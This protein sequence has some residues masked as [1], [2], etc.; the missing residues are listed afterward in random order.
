MFCAKI[1]LTYHTT[2]RKKLLITLSINTIPVSKKII[3]TNYENQNHF[4]NDLVSFKTVYNQ[5]QI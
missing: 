5:I 1:I 4:L 2:N 3:K